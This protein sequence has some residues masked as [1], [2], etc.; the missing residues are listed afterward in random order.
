M[1]RESLLGLMLSGATLL[2]GVSGTAL[3]QDALTES[4]LRAQAGGA[5]LHQA[6]MT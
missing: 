5:G 4:Q 2:A 6:S 3:A 1:K